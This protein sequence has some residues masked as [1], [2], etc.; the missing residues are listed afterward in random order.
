MV[1]NNTRRYVPL[2]GD[3]VLGI[4][5]EQAGEYYR[6]NVQG[7]HPALLHSLSFEG[8]TKRNRPHLTPGSLLYCR[9][10]SSNSEMDPEVSCKVAGDGLADGGAR[11]RDWMTDEGTYGELKGGTCIRVSLGLARELLLPS[12]IVLEALGKQGLAFEVAI[13]VN[14][15]VWLHSER[16]EYTVLIANAVKNS[17]VMIPSEVREM[18]ASLVKT[19]RGDFLDI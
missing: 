2:V 6:L 1:L 4:V 19:V 9:V 8:A 15:F 5:E 12:N 3:R 17:E 7:S 10:V 13:G 16:P 14:G 11:R 18:V